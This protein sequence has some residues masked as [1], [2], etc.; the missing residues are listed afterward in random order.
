MEKTK[1][2]KLRVEELISYIDNDSLNEETLEYFASLLFSDNNVELKSCVLLFYVAAKR[3]FLRVL[4]GLIKLYCGVPED[5]LIYALQNKS[6]DV[7]DYLID[8]DL[9][10]VTYNDSNVVNAIIENVGVKDKR[11]LELIEKVIQRGSDINAFDGKL[12]Y[13]AIHSQNEELF[14]FLVV[15]DAIQYIK[16]DFLL[17]ICARYGTMSMLEQIVKEKSEFITEKVICA[18]IDSGSIEKFKFLYNKSNE[19][20]TIEIFRRAY[21]SAVEKE[22]FGF[23]E[24]IL[25]YQKDST[26]KFLLKKLVEEY[27]LKSCKNIVANQS[28]PGCFE[29]AEFFARRF[30]ISREVINASIKELQ[31]CIFYTGKTKQKK[32]L[33]K[34]LKR[35]KAF[36]S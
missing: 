27:F 36:F 13:T 10:D 19:N 8:N 12:L 31:M 6:D 1:D 26:Q 9:V 20:L 24:G 21:I 2:L 11:G 14:A 18:S 17:K 3:N 4:K 5:L 28:D 29:V 33:W 7:V 16:E 30:N 23:L 34:L 22:S 25:E 35:K 15:N 32:K